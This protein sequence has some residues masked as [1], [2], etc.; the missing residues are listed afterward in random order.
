MLWETI[1]ELEQAERFKSEEDE[2]EEE[3]VEEEKERKKKSLTVTP[4]TKFCQYLAGWTPYEP[5]LY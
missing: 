3:E 2:Q 5:H 1:L 4:L